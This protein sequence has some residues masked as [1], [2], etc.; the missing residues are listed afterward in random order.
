MGEAVANASTM[1]MT[2]AGGVV[3]QHL[4]EGREAEGG[5]HGEGD[6]TPARARRRRCE[7]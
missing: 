6:P 1:G 7:K 3:Q 5:D 4:E 2:A